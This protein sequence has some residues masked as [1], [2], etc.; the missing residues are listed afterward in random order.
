MCEQPNINQDYDHDSQ[1]CFE[2]ASSM[3]FVYS[4]GWH[5]MFWTYGYPLLESLRT[6][7]SSNI[8]TTDQSDDTLTFI[9]NFKISINTVKEF[10]S[11]DIG[12]KELLKWLFN[13]LLSPAMVSIYL[14]IFIGLTPVL[15]YNIFHDGASLHPIGSVLKTVGEPLVCINTFIMAASLAHADWRKKK[16]AETPSLK[17]HSPLHGED[18]EDVNS[19][20]NN[21]HDNDNGNEN[22][23]QNENSIYMMASDGKTCASLTHSERD[24]NVDQDDLPSIRAIVMH[25]LF[26]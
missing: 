15:K 5:I 17:V 22:V 2:E 26:R 25:T 9:Q 21:L 20:S 16:D 11:T 13:V 14:G 1:T 24:K 19:S 12:K 10:I 23:N 6:D 7:S 8:V 18:S 4:I 3:L